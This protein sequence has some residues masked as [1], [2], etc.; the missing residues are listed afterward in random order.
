[1]PA[2]VLTGAPGAGK[3][4]VLRLLETL[5]YPVVEEA[6]TDVI[7]LD[8]ALGRAEPWNEHGFIDEAMMSPG[9]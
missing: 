2:Y 4:A 8:N 5:G 1:M 3:T 9:Q 6:A 7:A